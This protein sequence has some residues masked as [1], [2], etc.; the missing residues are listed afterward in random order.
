MKISKDRDRIKKIKEDRDRLREIS[1]CRISLGEFGKDRDH[2]REI[3]KDGFELR[4]EM[5]G[6]EQW[7]DLH[8]VETTI[9][10]FYREITAK[11]YQIL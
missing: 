8:M 4:E 5:P 6:F 7:M 11:S 9:L 1:T 10:K 2:L 3:G